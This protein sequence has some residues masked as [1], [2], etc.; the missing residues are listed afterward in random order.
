MVRREIVTPTSLGLKAGPALKAD[1]VS[2]AGLRV[3][4]DPELDPVQDL[5]SAVIV[6]RHWVATAQIAP[7]A[8]VGHYPRRKAK[9]STYPRRFSMRAVNSS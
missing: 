9:R 7:V 1:P 6:F 2:R 8:I 5:E 3:G 4:L